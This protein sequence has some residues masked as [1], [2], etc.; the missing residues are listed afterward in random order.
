MELFCGGEAAFGELLE[1]I[2]AS[3]QSIEINMF[4]WRDD[5][6]GRRVLEALLEAARRGVRIT[7]RKDKLGSVFEHAEECRR[8]MFHPSLPPSLALQSFFL[9]VFY[10]C[11]ARPRKPRSGYS[12]LAREFMATPGVS[13][14]LDAVR[15]D[16][17]KFYIFDDEAVLLGGMNVEQRAFGRDIRGLEFMDFMARLDGADLV[18]RF[19]DRLAGAPPDPLSEVDFIINRNGRL[20]AKDALLSLIGGAKESLRIFMAYVGDREL[21]ELIA[22]K[23]FDIPVQLIC[24]DA[25]NIQHDLNL[26]WLD[27]LLSK[28]RAAVYLSP[29]M[30]H[31]KAVLVDDAILT[32][33]SVNMNKQGLERLSEL[34]VRVSDPRSPVI[35]AFR[36]RFELEKHDARQ[37]SR[38]LPANRIRATIEGAV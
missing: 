25:A 35:E 11:A 20:E 19:R 31:A 18:K 24:P 15:S 3:R 6:I 36:E 13:A 26:A 8:S 2:N 17:S 7:L 4:I 38:P 30:V 28:S 14:E 32:F 29:K 33:G 12:A 10:P 16:H 21:L 1:R 22:R 27:R 5:E 9:G 37:V 23:S 34:N